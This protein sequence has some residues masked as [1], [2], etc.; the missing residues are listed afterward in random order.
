MEKIGQFERQKDYNCSPIHVTWF[1]WKYQ[2]FKKKSIQ[3]E[4]EI[5]IKNKSCQENWKRK[6]W[7][8]A[9]V[10]SSIEHSMKHQKPRKERSYKSVGE[11]RR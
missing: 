2:P 10:L 3:L 5:N 11:G 6:Q 1:Q 4:S 9:K 8:E 7:E